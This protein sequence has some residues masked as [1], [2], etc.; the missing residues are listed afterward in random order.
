MKLRTRSAAASKATAGRESMSKAG[1]AA[2]ITEFLTDWNATWSALPTIIITA[3]TT[4]SRVT[5]IRSIAARRAGEIR[6]ILPQAGPSSKS[7]LELAPY[8]VLINT[9]LRV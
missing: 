7:P 3:E 1:A 4:I 5:D 8:H 6:I 9:F 2:S